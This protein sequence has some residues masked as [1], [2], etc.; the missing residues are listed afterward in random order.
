MNDSVSSHSNN[1]KAPSALLGA[2]DIRFDATALAWLAGHGFSAAGH[3]RIGKFER[4][5]PSRIDYICKKMAGRSVVHLGCCDHLPLVK[6]KIASGQWIHGQITSVASRCLGVDINGEAIATIAKNYGYSN[7][8]C[9]DLTKEVPTELKSSTWDV[10]L[11]GEILEHIDDPVIFLRALR[12]TCH[13]YVD[14]LMIT[15]PNALSAINHKY[16]LR[17]IERINTDHRYW[18]TPFTLAKVLGQAG[19]TIQAFRFVSY[20]P[21]KNSN[22]VKFIRLRLH[23][24]LRDCLVMIARF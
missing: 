17:G 1:T 22:V 24:P 21:M 11:L 3:V 13:P 20:F 9:A 15:V 19:F 4:N 18:F 6:N 10:L 14:T 7:I 2:D 16:A 8:V 12:Q 5:I 23:P